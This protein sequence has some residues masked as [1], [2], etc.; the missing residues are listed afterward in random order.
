M[1]ELISIAEFNSLSEAYV[2]KSRL[3]AEG[4]R[5]YLTNEALNSIYPGMGFTGVE[6]KVSLQDSM[7]AMDILFQNPS[8]KPP[9][10]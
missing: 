4:I 6:L 9:T 2:V 5:C 8:G 3:E 7:Q 1:G 10:L